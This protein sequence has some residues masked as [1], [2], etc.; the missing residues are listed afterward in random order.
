MSMASW[1][2][3]WRVWRTRTW[4]GMTTG[5]AAA[6]SWQAARAG[7]TAA[8]RSSASIR[9]I[10]SG[11]FRPPRKRRTARDRFR[12]QRH[13]DSEHGRGQDG[14]FEG[15]GGRCPT[16]AARGACPAGSCAGVRGTA[17]G[18]RRWPPPEA[19]SRR[20]RRT[21]SAEPAR[22]ARLIRPPSG[23]WTTSCIPPG[24][25]EEP[26][27][28]DVVVGG[29][30]PE[31]AQAGGQVVDQLPA[32][33]GVESAG[34]GQWRRPPP[35][36]LIGPPVEPPVAEAR[37]RRRGRGGRRRPGAGARPPRRAPRSGWGPPHPERDGG[38]GPLGVDHPDLALAHPPDP[39]GVGARGG[40]RR[41]PWTRWRSPRSPSPP[42]CRRARATTR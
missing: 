2:Q 15:G 1:R 40:R 9:W 4:S 28:H 14:L 23:A 39:P 41:R 3:S 5:P 27:E 8:M 13:R 22:S 6:F 24:L 38:V 21:A 36:D 34:R 12:F 29:E 17:R 11:F 33:A 26:L 20:W 10:G 25:V 31:L 32:S 18:R 7:K 19:R 37:C 42:G 35:G 16:A 30:D